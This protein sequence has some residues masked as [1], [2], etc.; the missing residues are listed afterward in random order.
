VIT[1]R[2]ALISPKVPKV[3]CIWHTPNPW[4]LYIPLASAELLTFVLPPTMAYALPNEYPPAENLHLPAPSYVSQRPTPM[5]MSAS[6]LEDFR[7]V[8]TED[9]KQYSSFFV[10]PILWPL[11]YNAN[12]QNASSFISER[13]FLQSAARLFA[14]QEIATTTNSLLTTGLFL[15]I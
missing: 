8:F 6:T 13:P 5:Y 9:G 1:A 3:W 12:F 4:C 7:Q 11:S 10:R 14:S 2:I 15:K